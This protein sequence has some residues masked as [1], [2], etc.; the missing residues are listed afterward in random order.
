[1][2]SPNPYGPV[3]TYERKLREAVRD[4]ETPE[5]VCEVVAAMRVQA[6]AG[7]KSSPAAAKVY[8]EAVGL[9]KPPPEFRIDLTNAPPEV[10]KWLT[11]LLL[12]GK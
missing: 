1:M 8:L 2:P 9:P 11:P 6:L 5:Q 4:S 12:G 7:E 10:I 3:S